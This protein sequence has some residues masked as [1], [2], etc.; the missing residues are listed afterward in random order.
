ME[1]LNTELALYGS[2]TECAGTD[3]VFIPL[4]EVST[5]A[6]TLVINILNTERFL[7]IDNWLKSYS[8]VDCK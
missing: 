3:K 6:L 7:I 1:S 5:R 2:K 4:S 8:Y